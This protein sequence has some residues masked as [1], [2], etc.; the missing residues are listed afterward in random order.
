MLDR[1]A[2]VVMRDDDSSVSA[3]RKRR[4]VHRVR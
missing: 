2:I 4:K 3:E 1:S